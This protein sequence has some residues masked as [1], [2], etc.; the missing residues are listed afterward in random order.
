MRRIT[1]LQPFGNQACYLGQILFCKIG[2]SL[3][4]RQTIILLSVC[5]RPDWQRQLCN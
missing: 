5:L 1:L 2:F 4:R 3:K